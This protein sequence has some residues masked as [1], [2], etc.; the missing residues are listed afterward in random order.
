MRNHKDILL[1]TTL[2]VFSLVFPFFYHFHI[3]LMLFF[4]ILLIFIFYN[5]I[6]PF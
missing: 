4:I 5:L 3:V 1:T 2:S 6:F